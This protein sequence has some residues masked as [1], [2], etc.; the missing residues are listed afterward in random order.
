MRSMFAIS[1]Y[2]LVSMDLSRTRSQLFFFLDFNLLFALA[3]GGNSLPATT[4]AV[5]VRPLLQTRRSS[6]EPRNLMTK[7][8]KFW[9]SFD[10]YL[11]D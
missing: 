1:V 7:Q 10:Y 5:A 3:L 9:T 2:C 6:S 8:T 4:F 11:V